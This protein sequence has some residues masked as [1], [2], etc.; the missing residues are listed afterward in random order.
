MEETHRHSSSLVLSFF[1]LDNLLFLP[2]RRLL[3]SLC[4][5]QSI[6]PSPSLDAGTRSLPGP[7]SFALHPSSSP[8]SH[9]SFHHRD[10]PHTHTH[11]FTCS[12]CSAAP[13]RCKQY[14]CILV[15]LAR[16]GD[17][18][19]TP[20]HVCHRSAP[21]RPQ[22]LLH[23]LCAGLWRQDGRSTRGGEHERGHRGRS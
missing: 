23:G 1:S 9:C 12:A 6:R 13:A 18:Q 17:S 8:L 21:G 4:R 3:C 16:A 22:R 14:D 2:M 15:V 5:A 11:T 10:A 20:L 19:P 7:P